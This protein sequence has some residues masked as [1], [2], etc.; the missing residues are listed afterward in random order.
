MLNVDS[1]MSHF[2]LFC[3]VHSIIMLRSHEKSLPIF[4]T[5]AATWRM[6]EH[7]VSHLQQVSL[8]HQMLS[9][10]E[11]GQGDLPRPQVE[12]N[13]AELQVAVDNVTPVKL[14]HNSGKQQA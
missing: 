14:F 6:T 12:D 9:E 5:S 11:V 1:A 13:V 7:Y 2:L 3:S 4:G 8:I 10:A